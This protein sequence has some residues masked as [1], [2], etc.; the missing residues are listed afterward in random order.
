MKPKF[1]NF[2]VDDLI[3]ITQEIRDLIEDNNQNIK[4]CYRALKSIQDIISPKKP[5]KLKMLFSNI[6][7][8][9]K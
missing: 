5:S 4:D 6:I 9:R 8:N 1:Q 2:S 3:E 7:N